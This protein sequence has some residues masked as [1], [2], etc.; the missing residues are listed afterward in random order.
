MAYGKDYMMN[1]IRAAYVSAWMAIGL[2]C[3]LVAPFLPLRSAL[4]AA[5]L[6]I[7][8]I[9]THVKSR[10]ASF[11]T[12]S[13]YT[14][15][16][17]VGCVVSAQ[18]GP[19]NA[20][21]IALLFVGMLLLLPA[22]L[23]G[24]RRCSETPHRIDLGVAGAA[25]ACTVLLLAAGLSHHPPQADTRIKI[26][27]LLIGG[28]TSWFAV[29]GAETTDSRRQGR[30]LCGIIFLVTIAALF[31]ALVLIGT[32]SLARIDAKR[33]KVKDAFLRE[34]S[35]H[36]LAVRLELHSLGAA[37]LE[38]QIDLAKVLNDA[39]LIR[40]KSQALALLTDAPDAW[41]WLMQDALRTEDPSRAL[42]AFMH[43]NDK[44][45]S[46]Q[47]AAAILGTAMR[48]RDLAA[49]F[50]AWRTL[51][52]RMPPLQIDKAVQ[53]D[54]GRKLYFNGHYGFSEV[55]LQS[56]LEPDSAHW[57]A[58]RLLWQLYRS[59]GRYAQAA[60][61]LDQQHPPPQHAA[62]AAYLRTQLAGPSAD[63][64]P[65]QATEST[66]SGGLFAGTLRLLDAHPIDASANIGGA[67]IVRFEW[68]TTAPVNPRW[69]VFVHVREQEYG[70]CFFQSDHRF[71]DLGRVPRDWALGTTLT[72]DLEVAI[73]P[74][75]TPGRF[76]ILVG[77]WD[78]QKRLHVTEQHING[79]PHAVTA[80]QLEVGQLTV[81]DASPQ[82]EPRGQERR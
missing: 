15:F 27:A 51:R 37:S 69:K 48:E 55:C 50:K 72:Y 75:A 19:H 33:G 71:A 40:A 7:A 60:A 12:A 35:V 77:V 62:E 80:D 56:G 52:D 14:L 58:V 61:L 66:G 3:I 17:M 20:A 43:L 34:E 32:T 67:A 13:A 81:L 36:R 29:R 18:H 76:S 16:W 42:E 28:I 41:R 44:E 25:V 46:D 38:R 73:P 21:A 59:S 64:P 23:H 63:K 74:H 31:N 45:V 39:A 1:R 30:L 9:L 24:I 68:R 78:G 82:T 47:D 22:F 11:R 4:P 6:L 26:I 8:M 54:W 65:E 70:G 10:A 5:L 2:S 53:I 49:T 79:Q 57:D